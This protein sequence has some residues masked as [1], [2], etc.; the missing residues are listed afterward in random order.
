MTQTIPAGLD[1][2]SATSYEHGPPFEALT[3]LRRERPIFHQSIGDPNLV[4]SAWVVTRHADVAAIDAD[5]ERFSSEH[6]VSLHRRWAY[7]ESNLLSSDAPVHTRLRKLVSRGF[8]P[9]VVAQFEHH[10]RLVT[11]KLL[12]DV[13]PGGTFDFSNDLAAHLPG[14]AICELMGAPVADRADIIRATNEVVGD[15]DPDYG[16]SGRTMWDAM[17]RLLDYCREL[18]HLKQAAL[19][20]D[21]TSTLIEQRKAGGLSD[22]ELAMFM[23]LLLTGG[24]ESTRNAMSLGLVALLE[25]PDQLAI[26]RRDLDATIATAVDEIMRWSSPLIYMARTAVVPVRMHDQLIEPGDKVALMYLS[27]NRDERVFEHADRFDVRREHNRNLAFGIGPHFCLGAH[28]AKL[29]TR[30]LFSVLLRRLQSIEL[31]GEVRL[32]RSS[33]LHGVK[34]LPVCVRML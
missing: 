24:T 21:L 14:I 25:N 33:M 12:D 28:L 16:G 26:L 29:E 10:Y 19:G 15:S 32:L 8:T 23:F 27:A 31:A 7:T 3:Y 22:A 34:E 1:V 18:V 6:G 30:V 11:E 4:D 5:A 2:L 17:Q 9:R 20:D 13:L